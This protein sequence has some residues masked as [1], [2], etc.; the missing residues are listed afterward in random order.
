LEVEIVEFLGGVDFGVGVVG[1]PRENLAGFV[2]EWP[3]RPVNESFVEF[4]QQVLRD[5]VR[6]I[7][8]GKRFE[9]TS[10]RLDR[11]V[12]LADIIIGC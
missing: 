6:R 12:C 2:E 8:F 5:A 10:S 11:C 3:S 1:N 9:P 7:L 4:V